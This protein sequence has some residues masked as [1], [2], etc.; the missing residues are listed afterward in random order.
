MK[1]ELL[2]HV[3][4]ELRGSVVRCELVHTDVVLNTKPRRVWPLVVDE[5][6]LA[7]RVILRPFVRRLSKPRKSA[8]AA[9][10]ECQPPGGRSPI[11]FFAGFKIV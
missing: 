9:L 4:H 3:R 8:A 6:A 11:S 2:L 7:I 1:R 10:T 5:A